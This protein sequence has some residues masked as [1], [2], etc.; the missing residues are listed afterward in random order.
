MI[1]N[2][3]LKQPASFFEGYEVL[4]ENEKSFFSLLDTVDLDSIWGV[5]ILKIINSPTVL[6]IRTLICELKSQ[7][8]DCPVIMQSILGE[9]AYAQLQ[10]L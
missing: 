2:Q 10:R 6:K 4:N 9:K 7:E 1:S 3:I 8:H 5:A